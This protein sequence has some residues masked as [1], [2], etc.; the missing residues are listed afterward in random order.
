[1]PR[2]NPTMDAA[3]TRAKLDRFAAAVRREAEGAEADPFDSAMAAALDG[4][5]EVLKA[6]ADAF[7]ELKARLGR[8]ARRAA[9]AE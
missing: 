7:A 4:S 6:E 3:S 5:A 2:S 9:T 8:L 1:M